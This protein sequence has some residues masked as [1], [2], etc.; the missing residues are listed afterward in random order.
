MKKLIFVVLVVAVMSVNALATVIVSDDFDGAVLD[1]TKWDFNGDGTVTLVDSRLIISTGVYPIVS[2]DIKA[3]APT[4]STYVRLE[5]TDVSCYDWSQSCKFGLSSEIAVQTTADYIA[6][7]SNPGN[8]VW[9]KIKSGTNSVYRIL[10]YW[11]GKDDKWDWTIEVFID[12]VLLYKDGVLVLDTRTDAPQT[13]SWVIPNVAMNVTL[14]TKNNSLRVG[15]VELSTAPVP[16]PATMLL[17]SLG[18]IFLR[19]KAS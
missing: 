2:S 7:T 16:E 1:T 4:A 5:M 15:S 19:R 3:S 17:L 10:P 18:T 9:L 8:G 14:S 11:V 6:V 12:K 13:G